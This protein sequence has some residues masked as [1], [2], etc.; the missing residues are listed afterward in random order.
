MCYYKYGKLIA[1]MP[2]LQLMNL[3]FSSFKTAFCAQKLIFVYKNAVPSNLDHGLSVVNF[4]NAN[5]ENSKKES[6]VKKNI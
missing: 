6:C 1:E 3:Y 5:L 4:F 2:T